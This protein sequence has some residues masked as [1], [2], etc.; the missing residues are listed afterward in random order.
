MDLT[1]QLSFEKLREQKHNFKKVFFYRICGTGMGAAASLLKEK[2][3][4]VEGGDINYFPPM[5]TYLE[6]MKIPC[7]NLRKISDDYLK[8]FDLIVVGNVVP[9]GKEDAQR[10]EEIGVPFSSFPA[11][12]GALVLNDI[13]VMGVAGTHGKT[14]TT[15][16]LTQIFKKLGK[17]P[18][19][20]IGGVIEDLPSAHVG[21]GEYFFI[22]ADEYDS[23]YFE[24]ISKFRLYSLDNMILTSLEFDHADIF[25]N[26][27]DIQ[28]EF[29][30]VIPKIKGPIIYHSD[31]PASVELKEEFKNNCW[32]EYGESDVLTIIEEKSSETLFSLKY[33]KDKFDFKTNVI[34]KHNILNLSSCILYAF[35]EGFKYE[36]IRDSVESLSMVKRRQE[37]RGFYCDTMVIDDFAHH[38]RSV[39]YTIDGIKKKYPE[40]SITVVLEPNSSTARSSI[41]QE[42]FENALVESDNVIL[43]KPARDTTVKDC[44]NLNYELIKKNLTKKGTPAIIVDNLAQLQNELNE[45]VDKDGIFLILSNGT[46]LDLWKSDFVKELRK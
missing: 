32:I 43:A 21:G 17:D 36:E 42:E 11:T 34:G 38:P 23:A 9:R 1:N 29:R 35:E 18:G 26:I 41:F 46:C 6:K 22:E 44:N 31:Y 40:K 25:N 27:N 13:N 2:G 30:E 24:K 8:T 12:L 10:I 39:H 15:Y 4:E 45:R 19:Y 7:H 37:V 3:I 14:T 20:F 33:G 28:D 16:F 5:S